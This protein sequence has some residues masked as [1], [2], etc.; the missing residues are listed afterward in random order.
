MS[1]CALSRLKSIFSPAVTYYCNGS[2]AM[3]PCLLAWSAIVVVQRGTWGG[4]RCCY[5]E[6]PRQHANEPKQ[7]M[8]Q[9]R[10]LHSS[11]LDC[12]IPILILPYI[13]IAYLQ[14]AACEISTPTKDNHLIYTLIMN[15]YSLW[16][17]KGLLHT[18]TAVTK[19]KYPSTA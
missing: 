8:K 3:Q 12:Y 19:L 10:K 2:K 14:G 16:V 18:Y 11:V 6:G 5:E 4:V 17:Q 1:T 9:V 15:T 13:S 7:Q